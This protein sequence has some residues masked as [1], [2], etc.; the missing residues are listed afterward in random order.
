MKKF[1]LLLSVAT[2]LVGPLFPPTVDAG[3][4]S[5]DTI[6]IDPEL[7]MPILGVEVASAKAG[8]MAVLSNSIEDQNSTDCNGFFTIAVASRRHYNSPDILPQTATQN[9]VVVGREWSF[10]SNGKSTRYG[11]AFGYSKSKNTF[12]GLFSVVSES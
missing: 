5:E 8:H 9:G 7:V 2:V 3:G 12:P 6:A 11:A 10:K 1:A 4:T